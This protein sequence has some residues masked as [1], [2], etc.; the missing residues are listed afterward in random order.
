[1]K[2]FPEMRPLCVNFPMHNR[3]IFHR[4]ISLFLRNFCMIILE[5]LNLLG[6]FHAT[7]LANLDFDHASHFSKKWTVLDQQ[8]WIF[9]DLA[10]FFDYAKNRKNRLIMTHDFL[11]CE[12]KNVSVPSWKRHFDEFSQNDKFPGWF[13]LFSV[14]SRNLNESKKNEKLPD[15]FLLLSE[16]RFGVL[17]VMKG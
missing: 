2:S 7:F 13:W 9:Q 15:H 12:P 10:D 8:I 1:M 4:E 16:V 17:D 11:N 3:S 6:N 5:I 14:F